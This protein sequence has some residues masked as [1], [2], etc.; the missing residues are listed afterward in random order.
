M[1]DRGGNRSE[2]VKELEGKRVWKRHTCKFEVSQKLEL[3]FRIWDPQIPI[4]I[5]INNATQEL[6][7]FHAWYTVVCMCG[8]VEG[9]KGMG[10]TK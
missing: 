5:N 10:Y 7:M 8:G 6:F 9:K 1:E 2:R 4:V 3:E